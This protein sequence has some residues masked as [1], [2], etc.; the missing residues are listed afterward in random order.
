[1][2]LEGTGLEIREQLNFGQEIPS[3]IGVSVVIP[4]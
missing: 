1:M 3:W 2:L 4:S